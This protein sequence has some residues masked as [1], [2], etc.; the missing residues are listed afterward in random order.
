MASTITNLAAAT[1]LGGT[2]N[3]MAMDQVGDLFVG[4]HFSAAGTTGANNIAR[5][6]GSRWLPLGKGVSSFVN[7][8]AID[9]QGNLYAGGN[10]V[11]AGEVEANRVARW[12]GR[13]WQPLLT[14]LDGLVNSL[15]LDGQVN[16]YAG[17][18]FHTAGGVSANYI[19]KWDGVR[20]SPLG[21]GM[22][23]SVYAL[24]VGRDGYLYAGG[25]FYTAGGVS[26]NHI[27]RW[28]GTTW[29]ALGQ[30]INGEVNALAV[31]STGQVYAGGSFDNAGGVTAHGI[32]RWDGTRW[33]SVGSGVSSV[34]S[35]QVRAITFD[36]AD[37]IYV[38]GT[39]DMAGSIHA[40]NIAQW[41]GN[42]WH[43]LGSGTDS[44]VNA[45]KLDPADHLYAGGGFDTA[46]NQPSVGIALWGAVD[47]QCGLTVGSYSFSVDGGPVVINI[48]ALGTIDCIGV[49]RFN[50][51]HPRATPTQATSYYWEIVAT[52]STGHPA[53]GYTVDLTLP[54]TFTP[55]ADDTLCRYGGG[56]W[57]CAASS[58]SANNK[59]ITRNGVNQLGFWTIGHPGPSRY[60]PYAP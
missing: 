19:A 16:L 2:I 56:T 48:T 55:D 7:S 20:W 29:S 37:T 26:A 39:F 60:F 41:R 38:G 58:F 50:R 53:T 28:N 52:A 45:L 59:T 31:D 24:V 40:N 23:R 57:N 11:S 21:D 51:V 35:V 5:W 9:V 25:A 49:E 46:G 10:F 4:G 34:D 30:G 17:G 13:T 44:P 27:A 3:A 54:T 14:G 47:K 36:D 15:A 42:A 8:L 32:A 18:L 6:D 43:A 12:N 22:N 1:G 33:H